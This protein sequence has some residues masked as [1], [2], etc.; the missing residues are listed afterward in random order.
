MAL[1]HEVS[2]I[3]T[4]TRDLPRPFSNPCAGRTLVNATHPI[5][6]NPSLV[7]AG[8][9][10]GQMLRQMVQVVVRRE[11]T[12]PPRMPRSQR[13]G[14]TSPAAKAF[15]SRA[16]PAAAQKAAAS[17]AQPQG[18][19]G[20]L[21]GEQLGLELDCM[22]VS[23]FTAVRLVRSSSTL[24]GVHPACGGWRRACTHAR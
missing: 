5:N 15:F 7:E 24:G 11:R 3:S 1:L 18:D 13:N 14:R 16:T 17:H 22:R 23:K 2:S 20:T 12:L 4:P 19:L 9:L 6:S 21:R 10:L 8:Q